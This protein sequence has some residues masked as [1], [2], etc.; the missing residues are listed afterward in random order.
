MNVFFDVDHTIVSDRGT[1]RPH[2]REVFGRLKDDGHL[3]YLWSGVG[4]RT[5]VVR[6][7]ALEPYVVECFVK[8]TFDYERRWRREATGVW[9]DFCIDDHAAVIEVFGGEIVTPFYNEPD[10]TEILR[11]YDVIARSAISGAPFRA[12]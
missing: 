6:A 4:R 9:P 3:V 2:A 1:L 5:E 7:H 12:S 11:V 10:D 8:P